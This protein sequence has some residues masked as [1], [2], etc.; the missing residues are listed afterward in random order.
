MS[1]IFSEARAR[2]ALVGLAL[3]DAGLLEH[4]GESLAV[5]AREVVRFPRRLGDGVPPGVQPRS[6]PG[7]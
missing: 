6:V 4:R 1:R 3:F 7:E 5:L 2:R